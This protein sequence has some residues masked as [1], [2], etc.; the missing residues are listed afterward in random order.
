MA[1]KTEGTFLFDRTTTSPTGEAVLCLNPE[2]ALRIGAVAA[3]L[4][5][6]AMGGS[7]ATRMTDLR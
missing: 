2:N 5:F 6:L 4:H 7:C 3:R 1:G